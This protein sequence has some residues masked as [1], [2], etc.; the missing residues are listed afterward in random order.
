[1]HRSERLRGGLLL[2]EAGPVNAEC[3]SRSAPMLVSSVRPATS[4]G[5]ASI[6]RWISPLAEA[7]RGA[8]FE[9]TPVDRL[10]AWS[11]KIL[12]AGDRFT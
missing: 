10:A 3:S 5:S 8:R 2:P 9:R 12:T 6:T 1:M 7:L 11:R 4:H